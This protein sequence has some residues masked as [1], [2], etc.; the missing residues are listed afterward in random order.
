M[1]VQ[2]LGICNVTSGMSYYVLEVKIVAEVSGKMS[3]F[4][5]YIISDQ[6][7]SD[8]FG[9]LNTATRLC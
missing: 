5:N 6:T 3:A 4:H 8:L 2:I 9:A 1:S 7:T